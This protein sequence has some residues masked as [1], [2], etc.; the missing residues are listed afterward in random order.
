MKEFRQQSIR[1]NLET[2]A[3]ILNGIRRFFISRQY[4]EVET[5]VRIP[6]PAPEGH[7]EA[8]PS[9]NW[10][11]HTSPEL[12]MKRL[13][14]AGYDRIFQIC[15]CF[16]QKERGSKHLPELTLL[17]WYTAHADYTQMMAQCRELLLYLV[18]HLA[19]EHPFSYQGSTINLHA[20]W[21]KVS[22]AEAFQRYGSLSM[23][24][25]LEKDRF[26]E[27][28]G[29]EIEPRLGWDQPTLLHDYPAACG[30]LARPKPGRKELVE[31]FELY[32]A[33][34]ELCNGFSELTDPVEQRRRFSQEI[35]IA[36]AAGKS[37][38]PM[39][40]RFLEA[41]AFMPAATGNALGVDRLTMLFT[42]SPSINDVVAFIPEEL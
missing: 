23:P 37:T 11:L 24:E 3:G 31:R 17:E 22:V 26:D 7:I 13:L 10:F 32:I 15:K 2:R 6:A 35:A 33:G 29:L 34:L 20:E 30:S 27:I 8:E 36:T 9:R 1:P 4:L 39:P 14:A 42:D 16:R 12:C 19:L 38:G 18:E 21:E 25:A 5:P 40:E 41:L 28:M